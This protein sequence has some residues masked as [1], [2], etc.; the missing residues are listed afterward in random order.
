LMADRFAQAIFCRARAKTPEFT[1]ITQLG[2]A[3]IDVEID[4][5]GRYAT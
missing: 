3:F 5:F 1:R 4:R 2:F